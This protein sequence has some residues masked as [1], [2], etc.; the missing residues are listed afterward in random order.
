MT[1]TSD[2]VTAAQGSAHMDRIKRGTA[3]ARCASVRLSSLVLVAY[4]VV[5]GS[6]P[7]TADPFAECALGLATP[8]ARG[9]YERDLEPSLSG[10]LRVGDERSL[11]GI[12][13]AL[14]YTTLRARWSPDSERVRALVGGRVGHRPIRRARIYARSAIGVERLRLHVFTGTDPDTPRP[15]VVAAT[16]TGLAADV[17]AGVRVDLGAAEL[18]FEAGLTLSFF[19]DQG[20]DHHVETLVTLGTRR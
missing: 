9:P 11:A 7:A 16:L 2:G 15:D 4:T 3:H 1:V 12:E 19:D 10:G 18:G 14:S 13:L 17:G 6:A 8:V 5:T 20:Q